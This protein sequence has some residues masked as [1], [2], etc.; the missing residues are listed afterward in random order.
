M[1]GN[2]N[3]RIPETGDPTGAWQFQ[4]ATVPFPLRLYDGTA[5]RVFADPPGFETSIPKPHHRGPL[6]IRTAVGTWEVVSR[7]GYGYGTIRGRVFNVN[8]VPLANRT[9]LAF[10]GPQL[11]NRTTNANGEFNFEILPIDAALLLVAFWFEGRDSPT[12]T[13]FT[14]SSTLMVTDAAP[15]QI[16]DFHLPIP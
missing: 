15:H 12:E 6:M 9:V 8:G 1:S 2:L 3:L 10:S 13:A 16:F 11:A 4:V 7:E 5:W 14:N